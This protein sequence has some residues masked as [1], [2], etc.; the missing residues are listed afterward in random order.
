MRSFETR[1]GSVISPCG[2]NSLI[3]ISVF[4]Y[5]DG[6][7]RKIHA[8]HQRVETPGPHQVRLCQ[9]V[10]PVPHQGG[11]GGGDQ[12]E[13]EGGGVGLWEVASPLLP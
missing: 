4:R 5:E 13:V 1:A 12:G 9:D 8:P 6:W 2:T 10:T 11:G 3:Q 7:V